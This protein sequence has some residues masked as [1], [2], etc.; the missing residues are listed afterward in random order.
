MTLLLRIGLAAS[1]AVSAASHAYLYVH[2][3][4]HIPDI[5]AAFL[6]QASASFAIALLI[7]LGGPGWLRWAGAAVA[8][9]S[10]IAFGLSRTIGVM[11]FSEQ[12]WQPAPH[13]AISV[14]AEVL[15]VLLWAGD[16]ATARGRGVRQLQQAREQATSA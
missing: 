5:G 8:G 9:G 1:L 15:T 6:V 13:A 7:L 3:Y 2:G 4:R 14:T 16:L 11:G 12:G 10:L